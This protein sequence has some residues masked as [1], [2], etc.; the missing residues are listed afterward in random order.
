MSLSTPVLQQSTCQHTESKQLAL[1][2]KFWLSTYLEIQGPKQRKQKVL[3][4]CAT[5]GLHPDC[6]KVKLFIAK[7]VVHR[8]ENFGL[9]LLKYFL[10]CK[11]QQN[12]PKNFAQNFAPDFA[13]NFTP[14]CPPPK[15]KLCPE[16]RSAET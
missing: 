1:C 11:S 3:K 8:C 5:C 13:N 10:L 4:R 15:R 16:L 2:L 6:H 12:K 14:D 9:F 7:F